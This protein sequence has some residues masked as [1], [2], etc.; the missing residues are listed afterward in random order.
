MYDD[1]KRHVFRG[2]T[3]EITQNFR[4]CASVIEWVNTSFEKL[5]VE[6]EGVQPHYIALEPHPDYTHGAV[7]VVRGRS[8]DDAAA[9]RNATETRRAEAQGDRVADARGDRGG[10]V[11]SC[12]KAKRRRRV[13]R[14]Y[15]DVAILVPTRTELHL[16]EDALMLANVPYRHEGGRTFFKRQEVRELI[17]ILRAIDDPSDQ[18]AVIAALRS[19]AFACSDEDLFLHRE[20]WRFDYQ[21]LPDTATGLVA[22]SLRALRTLAGRRFEL[23]LPELVRELIDTLRLVEFA[24]LQHQGDQTAANLL[25]VIDQARAFSEARRSARPPGV[26]ALAQGERDARRGRNRRFGERRNGRC[27]AH[28]YGACG[29]GPRIWRRGLREHEYESS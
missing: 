16:Y 21:S 18:V 13:R 9:L 24:M 27:R 26:R 23:A 19:P 3:L 22:D 4:S 1:V 28:R 17:A 2:Q 25:K 5:I 11:A 20:H 29:Q 6:D 15:R 7:N 14:R 8:R 10:R 12:V